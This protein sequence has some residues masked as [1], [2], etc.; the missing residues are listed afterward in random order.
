MSCWVGY[1]GVGYGC[2]VAE[3]GD[4]VCGF[5]YV[6]DGGVEVDFF[7]AD[8]EVFDLHGL[9]LLL[10]GFL[11]LVAFLEVGGFGCGF[12]GVALLF[13]EFFWEVELGDDFGVL[14]DEDA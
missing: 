14:H 13:E 9:V 7:H 12:D 11:L 1:G 10:V 8:F 6:L 5:V 4:D 3:S 2:A